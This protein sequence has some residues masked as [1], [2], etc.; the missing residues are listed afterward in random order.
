[1]SL[2]SPSGEPPERPFRQVRP[3]LRRERGN[4][5]PAAA[6]GM[7]RRADRDSPRVR[8][9]IHVPG[10]VGPRPVGIEQRVAAAVV[11]AGLDQPTADP[12]RNGYGHRV[13][14]QAPTVPTGPLLPQYGRPTVRES[15]ESFHRLDR[16]RHDPARRQEHGRRTPNRQRRPRLQ[17]RNRVRRQAV[18]G[19]TLR[20]VKSDGVRH[21]DAGRPL[22]RPGFVGEQ[23]VPGIAGFAGD[24]EHAATSLSKAERTAL[25][26]AVRPPVTA[27]LQVAENVR[28]GRSASQMQHE[29]DVLDDDP[30]HG[31]AIQQVEQLADDR[32]LPTLYSPFVS[33]HGQVLARKT[34]RDYLGVF[35]QI[36]EGLGIPVQPH[37]RPAPPK[38]LHRM[39]VVLAQQERTMTRTL[40]SQLEAADS[41]EQT[42][43]AH[44]RRV[45]E[46]PAISSP[47]DA[48]RR[49]DP[50]IERL[51][52]ACGVYTIPAVATGILDAVGW[53]AEVDLSAMR[54]LEPAAGNG[55][56][57]VQAAKRLIESC[58]T[59]GIAPTT[60]LLR[61]RITAFE[62]HPGAAS[63][64]RLRIRLALRELGVHHAT[65][66]RCANAWVRTAD[67]LLSNKPMSNYTQAVGNPPY[68]R[69]SK[70]PGRLK[71]TY[72]KRLPR[73]VIRGDL[74]LPFLD[75]AFE[76][77]QP[78][79]LCGFLCS[80]R[81]M[82]MA[83][84]QRFCQ[85]WLPWLNVLSNN[86]MDAASVFARRVDAYPTILIASKRAT[87]KLPPPAPVQSGWRTLGELGCTIK[88]GPA[89]GHTPAFVL[90]PE[91]EDVEPELLAP[92]VHASEIL[93]GSIVWRG[94]RVIAMFAAD[95]N[96]VDPRRHPRLTLRLKRFRP[97]LSNRSIVRRGAPWYRTIDRTRAIDWRRPKL[98]VPELAKVPRI[99]FDL[100]GAVPSH[101]V[102]AIFAPDDRI[103]NIYERLRDGG[104]AEALD[105]I[106]PKLKG[107]YTRCYKRFLSRI[108]VQL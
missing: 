84:A 14:E 28:D 60:R 51:H 90:E 99:A 80:D 20:P 104:L 67:F 1:M 36:V 12:L 22:H 106:A 42:C 79:G 9:A 10:G 6:H 5:T 55:E 61:P 11:A 73:H 64:A 17:R 68:M 93:D 7:F 54:L 105:G 15:L 69:W 102:Y 31:T 91:E 19:S 63:E 87:P 57:V 43:N 92:W 103:G 71:S 95:G 101:G 41:G 2:S 66:S 21:V 3:M 32:A 89:L 52:R 96:I 81:W 26:D 40:E 74:F 82:Y 108:C 29:V 85:K 94:R 4:P 25:D 38:H 58:R 35:R 8:A 44:D 97:K 59:R 34:G 107:N 46:S 39:L 33:G 62:L 78:E 45:V 72:E 53:R 48:D 65:A 100:S 86:R 83:F 18:A 27:L 88:A 50:S 49:L 47:P 56:F 37:V 75:R 23:H 16:G 13:A 24:D 70:I 77:L 30:P 98:L 76:L